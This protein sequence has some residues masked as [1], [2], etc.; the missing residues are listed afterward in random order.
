VTKTE[1]E[2][3]FED[4]IPLSQHYCWNRRWFKSGKTCVL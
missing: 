4:E 3:V 2:N 1:L